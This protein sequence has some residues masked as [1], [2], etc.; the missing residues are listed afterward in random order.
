[1]GQYKVYSEEEKR[2]ITLPM[3]FQGEQGVKGEPGDD[4]VTP[5]FKIVS[6]M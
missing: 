6:G 5:M 4:G 3:A 1:M 2:W